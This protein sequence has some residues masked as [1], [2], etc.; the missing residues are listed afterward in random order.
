MKFSSFTTINVF[1]LC[2]IGIGFSCNRNAAYIAEDS[3]YYYPEK[4]IYYDSLRSQ[5][6]Y[7]LNGN[8]TWDSMAFNAPAFGAVLGRRVSV[9]REDN[10]IWENNDAHRKEF[11][12]IIL[13]IINKQT[14]QLSIT[15]SIN[16]ARPNVI[17]KVPPK[18]IE[19]EEPPKKGLKKFF[20]RLFG[21]KKK[22]A[23][24]KNKQ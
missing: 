11:N 22:P 15:D 7:S 9:K 6:Y 4:N 20:N 1:F 23:E 10:N 19:K 17:A 12:G 8:R 5:Y 21:K 24:E 2:F 3:I 16:K 13:N 14:I 18:E